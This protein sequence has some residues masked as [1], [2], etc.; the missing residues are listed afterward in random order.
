MAKSKS[1]SKCRVFVPNVQEL[2][3]PDLFDHFGL[4][5][6]GIVKKMLAP[7]GRF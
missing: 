3:D 4:P 6:T 5:L 1:T 2:F 7:L